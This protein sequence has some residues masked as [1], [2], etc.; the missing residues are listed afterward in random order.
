MQLHTH[1]PTKR[2]NKAVSGRSYRRA[3]NWRK[4]WDQSRYTFPVRVRRVKVA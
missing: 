1:A 3:A 2:H 4:A